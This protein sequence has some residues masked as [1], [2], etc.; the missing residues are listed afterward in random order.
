MRQAITRIVAKRS[1]A[2]ARSEYDVGVCVAAVAAA[3]DVFER[4]PVEGSAIAY[5]HAVVTALSALRDDYHDPDGEYTSGTAP[6][7][8]V[9]Y[10]VARLVD[11][12]TEMHEADGGSPS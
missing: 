6:I 4:V 5:G 10:D 11:A 2:A 3:R 8:D 1:Q 7:G 12:Q 9:F